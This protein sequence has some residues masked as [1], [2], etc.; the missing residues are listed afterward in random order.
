MKPVEIII[1]SRTPPSYEE[2]E[3]EVTR[4]LREMAGRGIMV[5]GRQLTPGEI[6]FGAS[7]L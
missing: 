4:A 3:R 2:L 7:P 1:K 5:N 6:Y